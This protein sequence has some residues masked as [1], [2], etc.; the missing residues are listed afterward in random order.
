[1]RNVKAKDVEV[2][3]V[4]CFHTRHKR[5]PD[6]ISSHPLGNLDRMGMSSIIEP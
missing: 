3:G 1:M 6:P 4:C 2:R 5:S